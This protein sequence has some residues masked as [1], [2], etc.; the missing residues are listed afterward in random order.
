M[1]LTNS[2]KI[3]KLVNGKINLKDF[4]I[5]KEY[6][7]RD[8]YSNMRSIAAC[9]IANKALASDPLAEPLTG[10]RV[11]YVI[12]CGMPGL[13]LYE[14]VR[15]PYDLIDNT[16]DLKL[17]YEYYVMKQVIPPLQRIMSLLNCNVYD[18]VKTLSFKPKVNIQFLFMTPLSN[19][20][21]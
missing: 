1:K 7:G 13:P 18:W 3:V 21:Y 15:S 17:N 8:T 12:V 20:I 16:S 19:F 14:L 10:E 5:A 6:R 9:Q 4:I 2:V 11:P